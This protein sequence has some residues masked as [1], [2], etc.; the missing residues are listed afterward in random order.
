[1]LPSKGVLVAPS[2]T[3]LVPIYGEAIWM[4]LYS[5]EEVR[6][7]LFD[8]RKNFLSDLTLGYM[9]A[10][11]PDELATFVGQLK[12][13]KVEPNLYTD[14]DTYLKAVEVFFTMRWQSVHPHGQKWPSWWARSWP[15]RSR[16]TAS[17]GLG[18]P[19]AL[20]RRGPA[21]RIPQRS[22]GSGVRPRRRCRLCCV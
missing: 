4:Q 17:G 19:S 2:L 6:S 5:P 16:L 14:D 9:M 7:K 12:D 13:R 11:F 1:M 18:P 10:Y 8:G 20:G 21:P 3:T 22:L 15:P